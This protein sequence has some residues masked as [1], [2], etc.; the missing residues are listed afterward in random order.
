MWGVVQQGISSLD[1][2]YVDYAEEHFDR[3]LSNASAPGYRRCSSR[4]RPAIARMKT[5]PRSSSSAPESR[6]RTHRAGT[7][8]R[9]G[10]TDVLV[11]ERAELTSGTTFHSAGLVGQ[12]RRSLPL[13]RMMMHSVDVYRRLEADAAR[14]RPLARVAEVGSLRIAST[15]PGSRSCAANTAGRRRSAC[16]WSSSRPARR[17][18]LPVERGRDRRAR[19]GLAPDRRLPRS[20]RAHVR[21]G[22]R[23]R[24]GVSVETER[25]SATW[26]CRTAVRGS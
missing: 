19:R 13:T 16:R 14:H 24:P 22:R 25:R 23:R 2:D 20:Q 1:Y 7:S 26:W 5:R 9:A 3:L 21:V 18:T 10:C 8:P 12:L 11:V 4:S 6:V 15:P 17:R